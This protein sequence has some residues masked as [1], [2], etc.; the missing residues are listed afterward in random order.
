MSKKFSSFFKNTLSSSKNDREEWEQ[1]LES[2][3]PIQCDKRLQPP[4][5]TRPRA[6]ESHH[7]IALEDVPIHPFEATPLTRKSQRKIKHEAS[8][9]LHGM[10]KKEA[11]DA[12]TRFIMAAHRKN[13][14]CILVITGKGRPAPGTL[15]TLFLQT[16]HLPNMRPMIRQISQAKPTDGGSGAFY[17]FLKHHT[18]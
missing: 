16:L 3:S 18:L 5:E 4:P 13:L 15:K 1:F 2:V 11:L 17:V 9:D 12:I 8:L 6:L 10:N 14:R 7:Q